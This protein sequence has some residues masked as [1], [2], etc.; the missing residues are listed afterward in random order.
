MIQLD[1]FPLL[2]NQKVKID[3][4]ISSFKIE[5]PIYVVRKGENLSLPRKFLASP[6]KKWVFYVLDVW[7][8]K[9]V[10]LHFWVQY[11]SLRHIPLTN[12]D[13]RSLNLHIL[14]YFLKEKVI[15]F[16][17]SMIFFVSFVMTISSSRCFH[18]IIIIFTS[19]MLII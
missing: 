10:K 19:I 14:L 3:N 5:R 12:Q 11:N 2:L 4:V 7:S 6:Y 16:I 17:F 15:N 13:V 1:K 18:H 9:L 8:K